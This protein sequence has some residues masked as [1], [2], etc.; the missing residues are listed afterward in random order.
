MKQVLLVL[1]GVIIS[2]SGNAQEVT[3]HGKI[4]GIDS[5]QIS[6]LVLP[7]KLGESPICDS[8]QCIHGEFDCIIELKL[9]MWHI[10]KLI[11]S[12]FN[13][14]FGEEKSSTQKLKNREIVFFIQPKDKIFIS[15]KIGEYGLNYKISGNEISNQRNEFEEKLYLFEEDY[16]RLTILSDKSQ[17]ENTKTKELTDKLN[18]INDKISQIELATI[19]QHPDWICSAERLAVFP[20]DTISKY[21]KTFTADV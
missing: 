19:V 20:T 16:N 10:V 21:F 5:A 12:A 15:A 7:L 9:N 4:E 3:F 11:S 8:I 2:I 13:S 14:V 1:I 17:I 6:V 18:L